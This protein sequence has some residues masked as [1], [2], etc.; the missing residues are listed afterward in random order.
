DDVDAIIGHVRWIAPCHNRSLGKQS[1]PVA[2]PAMRCGA[3]GRFAKCDA[4][5]VCRATTVAPMPKSSCIFSIYEIEFKTCLLQRPWPAVAHS[6]A[7][8]QTSGK[9]VKG[10]SSNSQDFNPGPGFGSP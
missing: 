7:R 1:Y 6:A 3:C 4:A 9:F 2:W 5:V 8:W 10:R